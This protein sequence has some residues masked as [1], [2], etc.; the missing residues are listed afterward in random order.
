MALRSDSANLALPPI[1]FVTV[2]KHL[3]S[4][5]LDE[6]GGPVNLELPGSEVHQEASSHLRYGN[7]DYVVR[8]DSYIF[9]SDGIVILGRWS[10]TR[11]IF[12]F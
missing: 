12:H 5:L 6:I 7:T 2:R 8:I 11:K 9:S 3:G 10:F 4:S 1:C